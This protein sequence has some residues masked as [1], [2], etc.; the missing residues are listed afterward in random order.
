MSHKQ[1]QLGSRREFLNQAALGVGWLAFAT[2][3]VQ[4]KP[5]HPAPAK[6]VI[7]LYMD[8]GMSHVDTFD[9]KPE[10]TK[11]HG[12]P[13]PMTIEPTQFD[14]SG[15]CL[16]SPWK[17]KPHGH[18][19]L[20]ISELFPHLAQHADELCMIR[21]MTNEAAT[22]AN[23]NYWMH[24]GWGQSGRPSLGAWVNYALGNE[25]DHL[26]GYVVL[27][28]GLLPIGGIDNYK[29][30]FLPAAHGPTL[31]DR[32]DLPM[33]NLRPNDP[34]KQAKQLSAISDFDRSFSDRLGQPDPIE[35]AIKNYELAAK[36]QTSVPDLL[37]LSQETK[38]TQKLYGLDDR[39]EHTR[40]YGRQCLLARRMVERGVRWVALTVPR[41]HG[42][43]RWDAH[44]DLKKN[45]EDHARMVDKPVAAL[46]S[47]LKRR[48]LWNEVLVVFATEFGRTPFSQGSDGRDHNQFGFSVWLAGG[49]TKGGFVYGATDEFGYKVVDK[50]M[51]VHD[52]H[53]TLLY[54][55]GLDHEKLTYRFGGRDHR[56]TDVHGIVAQ[57]IVA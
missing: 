57:D 53:A 12:Q 41:V 55:L 30:G 42:D 38:Q 5:H 43:N 29:S 32:S 40:T 3:A 20:W 17:T 48:G 9:P 54:L 4:A 31:F 7:W 51:T 18:N 22:H 37:D 25:A 44:S 1:S 16:K 56:L 47:D 26:P 36:M 28:A 24:T 19:G 23:A 49:G 13:F 45:H 8:G 10:L 46:L 34:L 33:P 35:T 14:S 21:S 15:P 27:N 39:Y 52:F 50:K 6:R 2:M 11:R